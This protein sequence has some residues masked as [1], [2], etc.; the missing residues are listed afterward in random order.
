MYDAQLALLVD[1]FHVPKNIKRVR[2]ERKP[3][4]V[5]AW[6]MK[7]CKKTADTL[8]PNVL[9]VLELLSMIEFCLDIGSTYVVLLMAYI[10]CDS[11][12]I[13]TFSF[14]MYTKSKC[15]LFP[16][17]NCL[18]GRLSFV[19]L[20]SILKI[21]VVEYEDMLVSM[22]QYNKSLSVPFFH[23]VIAS[24]EDVFCFFFFIKL[25]DL[26]SCFCRIW[27]PFSQ[28][29]IHLPCMLKGVCRSNLESRIKRY[30]NSFS[31]K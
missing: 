19:L 29:V 22:L 8:S 24:L 18:F 5:I 1:R 17:R 25:K 27:K 14:Y 30:N 21:H 28:Q 16:V 11:T 7:R 15:C 10:S 12:N 2:S 23:S 13:C 9:E 31:F 26:C 20:L 3:K 6:F 4:S